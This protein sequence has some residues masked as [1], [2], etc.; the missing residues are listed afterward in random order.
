MKKNLHWV[1][2][3]FAM[4][5]ENGGREFLCQFLHPE[6]S[7]YDH[8]FVDFNPLLGLYSKV[9]TIPRKG[10]N[11]KN[12]VK[13]RYRIAFESLE[14]YKSK[15]NRWHKEWEDKKIDKEIEK[16]LSLIKDEKHDSEA[17][18][19]LKK[20]IKSFSKTLEKLW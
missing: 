17:L 7:F 4:I 20:I 18:K 10:Q 16:L 9:I 13:R 19:L 2:T 5:D 11:Q 14:Q 15:T 3:L 12:N 6:Y 8:Q 1:L